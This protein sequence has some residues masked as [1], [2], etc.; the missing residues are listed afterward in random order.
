M[1]RPLGRA[2]EQH[3]ELLQISGRARVWL[4]RFPLPQQGCHHS[5]YPGG[6]ILPDSRGNFRAEPKLE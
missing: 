5:E 6:K 4:P 3:L 2:E 1:A